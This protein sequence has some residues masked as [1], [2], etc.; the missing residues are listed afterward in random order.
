MLAADGRVVWLQDR[1]TVHVVDGRPVTLRGVMVDITD[2]SAP[3][4]RCARARSASALADSAPML[5]WTSGPD[6]RCDFFNRRRREFT[7]RP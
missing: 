6:R 4:R 2:R 1:V 7:G 5:V 3:R